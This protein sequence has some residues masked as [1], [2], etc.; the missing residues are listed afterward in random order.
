MCLPKIKQK[1]PKFEVDSQAKDLL[2]VCSKAQGTEYIFYHM[3]HAYKGTIGKVPNLLTPM[4]PL[5]QSQKLYI[6]SFNSPNQPQGQGIMEH[7]FQL[8]QNSIL[9]R[10]CIFI[11][12]YI[13]ANFQ[14]KL[15]HNCSS[16]IQSK[17]L[18]RFSNHLNIE[19]QAL[20]I[21]S[22]DVVVVQ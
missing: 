19:I 16:Q 2:K 1:I 13:Y 7:F 17:Q 14:F 8:G 18:L 9:R 15:L 6:C 10:L 20:Y 4:G 22:N 11:S 3:P 12:V 5:L 21:T